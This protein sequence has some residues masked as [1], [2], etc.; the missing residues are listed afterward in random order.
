MVK[1]ITG[2]IIQAR[3]SSSRFRNKILNKIQNK[4]ILEIL[5]LRLKKSKKIDHFIVAIPFEDRDSMIVKISKKCGYNVILGSKNNLVARYYKAA[6]K[7]NIQNIIR[8]TSDCPLIDKR[9]ID[10]AIDKFK[11]KNLDF[12]SNCKPPTYPDG[13]DIEIFKFKLLKKIHN[14]KLNLIEKEHLTQKMY[15]LIGINFFNFKNRLNFSN[16]RITLDYYK[17]YIVIKKILKHFDYNYYISSSNVIKF[18]NKNKN[19]LKIN[20]KYIRNEK[21]NEKN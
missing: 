18:L 16:I 20:S 6:K 13:L 21:L 14:M 17:D 9:L 4:T 3:T 12:L 5:L 11:K 19:I 1:K 15:N 8:I 10:L 2:V 7:Y